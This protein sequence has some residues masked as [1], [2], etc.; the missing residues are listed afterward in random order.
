MVWEW[1]RAGKAFQAGRRGARS[2]VVIPRD[3]LTRGQASPG[4]AR[5]NEKRWGSTTLLPFHT[6]FTTHHVEAPIALASF[7]IAPLSKTTVVHRTLFCR[8]IKLNECLSQCVCAHRSIDNDIYSY[9]VVVVVVEY[10]FEGDDLL[11][12]L[13]PVSFPV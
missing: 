1:D 2:Y 13:Y 8:V 4:P 11:S 7:H 9:V 12:Q 3:D 6:W 5:S 10:N